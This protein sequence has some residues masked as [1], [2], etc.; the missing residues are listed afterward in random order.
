MGSVSRLGRTH[1]ADSIGNFGQPQ[2]AFKRWSKG[3][4]MGNLQRQ[5]NV[6]HALIVRDVQTRFGG[7]HINFLVALGWPL[8]HIGLL[9]IIYGFLGRTSPLGSSSTMFFATGLTPY[10]FFNYPSRFMMMSVSQNR[11]MMS[12]PVVKL[13]DIMIARAILETIAGCAV[14]AVTMAVLYCLGES[15]LPGDPGTALAALGA[16]WVLAVGYGMFSAVISAVFPAWLLISALMQILFYISSGILFVASALPERAQAVLSWNPLT[17]G[18]EWFRSAYYTDIET[19][20]FPDRLYPFIIG[21]LFLLVALALE[22]F[23][24][25]RRMD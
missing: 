22:R 17:Q 2:C 8:A 11:P 6:I 18:V 25:R 20:Y 5:A 7:K 4:T 16:M 24:I 21:M 14:I 1:S 10:M 15:V 9:L 23:V 12:F 19:E 3:V 13:M